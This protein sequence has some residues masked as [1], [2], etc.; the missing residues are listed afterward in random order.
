[1]KGTKKIHRSKHSQYNFVHQ[2]NS[3][4][5]FIKIYISVQKKNYK[6]KK[7]ANEIR[8]IFKNRYVPGISS[9]F[10]E[11]SFGGEDN[12][13][14]LGIAKNRDL[15]SFLEQPRSAFRESNLSVNLILNS[16]Q[17]HPSPPH[18]NSPISLSL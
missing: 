1:M 12:Q 2:V 17:L 13:G 10:A 16:L 9:V 3:T 7:K 8:K 11:L 6:K 14:D 4:N 15:M 18:F 5:D